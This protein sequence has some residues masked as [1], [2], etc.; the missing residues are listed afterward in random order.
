MFLAESTEP[1]YAL[2]EHEQEP[3]QD[4]VAIKILN[5]ERILATPNGIFNTI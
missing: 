5:K 1:K 4:R 3:E 2:N